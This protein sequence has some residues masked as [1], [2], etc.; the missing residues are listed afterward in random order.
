[1]SF[2]SLIVGR[3]HCHIGLG[4]IGQAGWMPR[5]SVRRKG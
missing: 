4:L 1:M 5:P 3:I 2:R